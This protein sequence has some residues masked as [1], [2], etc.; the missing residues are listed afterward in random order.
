MI[1]P[2][3][4]FVSP[5]A[6]YPTVGGGPLRSASLL[7]YLIQR[8]EV[9]LMV[10]RQ[11]GEPDPRELIP[12][13]KVRQVF[14]LDLPFHS[15]S[16]GARAARNGLRLVRGR[17]PLLDRFSGFG[18]VIDRMLAAAGYDLGVVEHF[19]CAPYAR[20]LRPHC[21]KLV[22]DLHNIESIWHTRLAQAG[23]AAARPAHRRFA[24]ACERLEREW[25]PC[26]DELLVTSAPDQAAAATLAGGPMRVT[27]YPNAL[28]EMPRVERREDC[29][30]VFSGNL[31]YEPNR[32]ALRFFRSRI[33]PALRAEFPDIEWCIVGKNPQAVASMFNGDPGIR[34]VGPVE[35]A[36]ATLGR[37]QIAVV[38]V[39]AG[40][41]TRI[42][43]L[44]A[45]AAGTPVVSTTI[46]AEGLGCVPGEHLVIAD[47]AADF[48]RAV[49][50]LLRSPAERARIGEA[51][52]RLYEERFTW[53]VAWSQLDL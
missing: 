38:P 19:W 22:L 23:G 40:S 10:F 11:P 18:K 21:R 53:P 26:F 5:E 46:G 39:L 52:R 14:V 3:A 50:G 32:S 29:S 4:L 34:I 51:G 41:G 20:E 47:G 1:R 8:Y 30:L 15:K 45:W 25:L 36:V 42:K 28:P 2:R 49:A 27:I 12:S 37:A 44:E 48:A 7:E 43:I 16:A 17:P 33:W 31:E 35:N 13:G 24:A 6:P 9:D